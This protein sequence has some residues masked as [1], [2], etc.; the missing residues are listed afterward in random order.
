MLHRVE[1]T[2]LHYDLAIG[3]APA[4]AKPKPLLHLLTAIEG[5]CAK[6]QANW[7]R[8]K[9]KSIVRIAKVRF[10][11]G[12]TRAIIL[13][14]HTDI[15]AADPS[16]A[17]LVSGATRTE[18]K[19]FGEGVAV[20]A[21]LVIDLRP[22]PGGG[23][24]HAVLENVPGLTKFYLERVFQAVLKEVATYRF[25]DDNGV[26]YQAQPRL[27][28]NARLRE[29][30]LADVRRGKLSHI[31]LIK[32]ENVSDM[33][34]AR[35]DVRVREASVRIDAIANRTGKGAEELV[36]WAFKRGRARGYTAARLSYQNEDG[37]QKTPSFDI[38]LGD[39]FDAFVAKNS[40]I[41]AD[42]DLAQCE[43]DI[44]PDVSSKLDAL[45]KKHVASLAA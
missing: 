11:K 20:S 40:T 17:A 29:S 2:A 9:G 26:A 27:L 22:T 1:R 39:V 15:D 36:E 31:T 8:D 24:Y 45:L 25:V 42:Y 28:F 5:A 37:K 7:H 32:R 30:L 13:L 6:G 35:A 16:F 18:K 41:T 21:H 33:F 3:A 14:Q 12:R 38:R 44:R 43:D 10:N 23:A 34:D 19:G 4:H